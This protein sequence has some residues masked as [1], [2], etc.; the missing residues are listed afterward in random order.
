MLGIAVFHV[1]NSVTGRFLPCVM[2]R[3]EP[4]IPPSHIKSQDGLTEQNGPSKMSSSRIY[5]ALSSFFLAKSKSSWSSAYYHYNSE[6]WVLAKRI[7]IQPFLLHILPIIYTALDWR[8]S[9]MF[10]N[11]AMWLG[12]FNKPIEIIGT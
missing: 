1:Q 9:I 2:T 3:T 5:P 6:E 7:D 11:H 8:S 4:S 10:L 12:E